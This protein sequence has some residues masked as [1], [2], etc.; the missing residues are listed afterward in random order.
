MANPW[1]RAESVVPPSPTNLKQIMR[2]ET[3]REFAK[4]LQL[5]SLSHLTIDDDIPSEL[6]EFLAQEEQLDHP[7]QEEIDPQLLRQFEEEDRRAMFGV[8][9]LKTS[10]VQDDHSDNED[11]HYEAA[12]DKAIEEAQTRSASGEIVT[13]Q[14]LALS[15]AKNADRLAT[16][17]VAE[18]GDPTSVGRI[19]SYSFNNLQ[20]SL[21][22]LKR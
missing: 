5:S 2:E 20:R 15:E 10:Q 14:D 21:G 3:D 6:L 7:I 16:I 13:R 9:T 1:R 19:S 4:K 12:Y 17:D 18:L 8:D 11:L 22:K